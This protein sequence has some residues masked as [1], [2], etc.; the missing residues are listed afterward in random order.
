[1]LDPHVSNQGAESCRIALGPAGATAQELHA[2]SHAMS[3]DAY[4]ATVMAN[5]AEVVRVLRE[6]V[7][8]LPDHRT[9]RRTCEPRNR[10]GYANAVQIRS[11]TGVAA[12]V[13]WGG[14]GG[15]VSVE[16]KGNVAND[17]YMAMRNHF[18]GHACSH[19]DVAFDL[20]A[21]SLFNEMFLHLRRIAM[22]DGIAIRRVGDWDY[23]QRGRS[24]YF[25]ALTSV[26]Q[27][28]LY[29][30]GLQLG[31]EPAAHRAHRDLVRLELRVRPHARDL[32]V[33]LGT[34]APCMAWSL[35]QWTAGA[36]LTFSALAAQPALRTLHTLD[37]SEA[38]AMMFDEYHQILTH[39]FGTNWDA[40]SQMA[41]VECTRR[42]VR[43]FKR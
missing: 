10:W 34:L 13:R 9:G 14:N 31:Q 40:L 19:L 25:G 37:E 17:A 12:N 38:L 21:P 24:A 20:V 22:D 15:G 26:M 27:V 18:P 8:A 35:S 23:F 30:K 39:R 1:V 3:V 33:L 4:N 43:T 5:P 36:A 2:L 11:A 41:A 32:K 28:V 29:E 16:I 6:Y 42:R 7:A